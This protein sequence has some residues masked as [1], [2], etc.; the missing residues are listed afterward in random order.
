MTEPI[1][2][3]D[4]LRC[5]EDLQRGFVL[6]AENQR[7]LMENHQRL[8]ESINLLCEVSRRLDTRQDILAE[9]CGLVI[10]TQKTP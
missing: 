5:L 9:A 8:Q 4:P 10:E 1:T 7:Q 2:D 3:F 6:L